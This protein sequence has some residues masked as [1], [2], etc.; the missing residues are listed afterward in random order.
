MLETQEPSEATEGVMKMVKEFEMLDA[1]LTGRLRDADRRLRDHQ[2]YK[3][4][5][6]DAS[7]WLEMARDRLGADDQ[8]RTDRQSLDARAQLLRDT[9]DAKPVGEEKIRRADERGRLAA[10]GSNADGR[11]QIEDE[12]AALAKAMKDLMAECQA[13]SGQVTGLNKRWSEFDAQLESLNAW[14][15]DR[16]SRVRHEPGLDLDDKRRLA[17]AQEALETEIAEK[18]VDLEA[19]SELSADLLQDSG[20]DLRVSTQLAKTGARYHALEALAREHAQKLRSHADDHAEFERNADEAERWIGAAAE[21]LAATGRESGEADKYEL[22]R[23]LDRVN[24][25]SLTKEEGQVLLQAAGH[26]ADKAEQNTAPKGRPAIRDRLSELQRRWETFT[27]ELHDARAAVDKRQMEWA[28]HDDTVERSSRLREQPLP[29]DLA[30]K[31]AAAQRARESQQAVTAYRPVLESAA[32]GCRRLGRPSDQLL[33]DYD[34]LVQLSADAVTAAEAAQDRHQRYQQAATDTASWL[35]QRRDHLAGLSASPTSSPP[36]DA[37]TAGRDLA[38]ARA[39]KAELDGEGEERLRRL[40]QLAD[41]AMEATSAAGQS[42]LRQEVAAAAADLDDLRQLAGDAAGRLERTGE[43]WR[44]F[45]DRSAAFA[46]WLSDIEAQLARG[47]DSSVGDAL[48]ETADAKRRRAEEAQRRHAAAA[49]PDRLA[50]LEAIAERAQSLGCGQRG[51]QLAARHQTACRAAAEASRQSAARWQA[52]ADLDASL[53]DLEQWLTAAEDRLGA[54]GGDAERLAELQTQL[55]AGRGRLRSASELADRVLPDTGRAGQEQIRSRLASLRDLFDKAAGATAEARTR[56]EAAVGAARECRRAGGELEAWLTD[57]EARASTAGALV[58]TSSKSR[59]DDPTAEQQQLEERKAAL[60][61]LRALAKEVDAKSGAF[62]R[63]AERA[64][65]VGAA[66]AGSGVVAGSE[67]QQAR[68]AADSL[69]RRFSRL[70]ASLAGRV[71]ELETAVSGQEEF[72]LAAQRAAAWLAQAQTR[73]GRTADMTGGRADLEARLELAEALRTEAN[74]EGQSLVDKAAAAGDYLSRNRPSSAASDTVSQLRRELATLLAGVDDAEAR[75]GRGVEQWRS[76]SDGCQRF[77]DWLQDAENRLRRGPEPSVSLETKQRQARDFQVIQ[78]EIHNR[79]ADLDKL[80]SLGDQLEKITRSPQISTRLLQLS[81]KYQTLLAQCT[82]ANQKLQQVTKDTRS[83][84]DARDDAKQ[85]IE[86]ATQRLLGCSNFSED[87]RRLAEKKRAVKDIADSMLD[88]ENKLAAMLEAGERVVRLGDNPD[89]IRRQMEEVRQD[90]NAL[91]KQLQQ[92]QAGVEKSAAKWSDFQDVSQ[93]L[94]SWLGEMERSLGQLSNPR[95]DLGERRTVQDRLRSLKNEVDR[96]EPDFEDLQQLCDQLLS[97]GKQPEVE[98]ETKSLKNRYYQLRKAVNAKS[99]E[100]N[101]AQKEHQTYQDSLQESEKWIL[102]TS[103][104]LME[105]NSAQC[106]SLEEAQRQLDQHN[107]VCREVEDHQRSIENVRRLGRRL[108]EENSGNYELRSEIE[109]QLSGLDESYAN[110]KETAEQIRERLTENH[111]RWKSYRDVLT[112]A[113]RYLHSDLVSWWSSHEPLNV[114]TADEARQQT[115]EARAVQSRLTQL[116]SEIVNAALKCDCTS[117]SVVGNSA[118]AA[119]AASARR[120]Y[121][122][123]SGSMFDGGSRRSPSPLLAAASGPS[124]TS[125]LAEKVSRD[126]QSNLDRIDRRLAELSLRRDGLE[127]VDTEAEDAADWL[128]DREAEA[129]SLQDASALERLRDEVANRAFSPGLLEARP[130]LRAQRDALLRK[131]DSALSQRRQSQA[132]EAEYRKKQAALDSEVDS[133]MRRVDNRTAASAQTLDQVDYMRLMDQQTQTVCHQQTQTPKQSNTPSTSAVD[134]TDGR[135][136]G[137]GHGYPGHHHHHHHHLAP[138][139]S[140]SD[141]RNSGGGVGISKKLWPYTRDEPSPT[142]EAR[143]EAAVQTPKHRRTQTA[144]TPPPPSPSAATNGKPMRGVAL[145]HIIDTVKGLQDDLAARRSREDA[146]A[147]PPTKSSPSSVAAE[148]IRRP[149]ERPLGLSE[150]NQPVGSL[151]ARSLPRQRPTAASL[152]PPAADATA[153]STP[154]KRPRSPSPPRRRSAAAAPPPPP[155]IPQPLI[156]GVENRYGL[157][158]EKFDKFIPTRPHWRSD[159]P[160]LL[161][162]NGHQQQQQAPPPPEPPRQHQPSLLPE[163]ERL[164]TSLTSL[165]D[166]GQSL[167]DISEQPLREEVQRNLS[168]SANQTAD[169]RSRIDNRLAELQPLAEEFRLLDSDAQLLC[170]SMKFHLEEAGKPLD[171]L[172][173]HADEVQKMLDEH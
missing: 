90:F 29:A 168:E 165:Q 10:E 2:Q 131:L 170:D 11:K 123:G 24:D 115:E 38:S 114:R 139:G 145:L 122:G 105:Q 8:L 167:M 129:N 34:A 35:R 136:Y 71:S 39:A 140:S 147:S 117:P 82:E 104:R 49:S 154:S 157:S 142:L 54:A 106:P 112:A 51:Q 84:E 89:R 44:D 16:E 94:G 46:A 69:C 161:T 60:E 100:L 78:E 43:A 155:P 57:A 87:P 146:V 9:V 133:V 85:W 6:A 138:T 102:Q 96:T 53:A 153:S 99:D 81:S 52:H 4:A 75:L 149:A 66:A 108:V 159:A 97:V 162:A 17:A 95:A 125:R 59:K 41:D 18:Q 23:Q 72:A 33:A 109:G 93:R 158:P 166:L 13:Q 7:E 83:F 20:V 36:T 37:D 65:E 30:E 77:A 28:E 55:E 144:Q 156:G 19:L 80:Q 150:D 107:T 172:P 124:E 50:E 1:E 111:Q 148:S 15:A 76:F 163:V 126:L 67:A 137:P 130:D 32:A 152:A 42:R 151:R 26:W 74:R 48:D 56:A 62:A 169:L 63:L 14:L 88:G 134:L 113:D 160:P 120:R 164:E 64:A 91:R 135:L 27:Q 47:A 31:R 173:L 121:S 116:R 141:L 119:A 118:A 171:R 40:R 21:R 143:E 79:K 101:K 3:E 127:R 68:E 5:V 132:V 70:Q 12:T 103:F 86:Q 92:V 98:A 45:N 58:P 22:Q 128:R 61:R 73:L 25:L 110:L